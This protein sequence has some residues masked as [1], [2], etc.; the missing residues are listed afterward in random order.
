MQLIEL[1]EKKS[2]IAAGM[3]RKPWLF[4]SYLLV[5]KKEVGKRNNTQKR[6]A[7]TAVAALEEMG[8]KSLNH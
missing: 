1:K 7:P 2:K 8:N 6:G 3:R 4:G 5:F